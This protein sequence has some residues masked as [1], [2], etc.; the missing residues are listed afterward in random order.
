MELIQ[1]SRGGGTG[2]PAKAIALAIA[3]RQ[4]QMKYYYTYVLKSIKDDKFYVGWTDNLKLRL[5]EHNGGRVKSTKSRKPFSLVYFEACLNRK[6][7]IKR[8]KQLKTGYGRLYIKRRLS[9]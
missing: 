8:E 1:T 7:A 3:G 9:T 5:K 4:M 6:L 2:P